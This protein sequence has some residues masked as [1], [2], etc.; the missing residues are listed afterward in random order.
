MKFLNFTPVNP[1]CDDV[2]REF[3]AGDYKSRTKKNTYFFVSL[4][5]NGK[6][7]H[8]EWAANENNSLRRCKQNTKADGKCTIYALGDNIVWGNPKLYK[9]LTGKK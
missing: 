7:C 6:D 1:V 9:E 2:R 3:N 5:S 8:Y 4:D